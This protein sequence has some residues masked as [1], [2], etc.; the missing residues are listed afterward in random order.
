MTSSAKQKNIN[1][2]AGQSI[3]HNTDKNKV[4]SLANNISQKV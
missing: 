3:N 4:S 1:N 2:N